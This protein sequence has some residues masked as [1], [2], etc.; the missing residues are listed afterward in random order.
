MGPADGLTKN[1]KHD[2]LQ[3]QVA[4]RS[5]PSVIAPGITGLV[6]RNPSNV[7]LNVGSSTHFMPRL[8]GVGPLLP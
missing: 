7:M 1:G 6:A 3:R 4:P 8:L 2:L 5:S